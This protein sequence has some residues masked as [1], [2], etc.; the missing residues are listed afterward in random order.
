MVGVRGSEGESQSEW[1]TG[2]KVRRR[3]GGPKEVA[4]V[5]SGEVKKTVLPSPKGELRIHHT[6]GS[7]EG[8]RPSGGFV[9]YPTVRAP[10]RRRA[11]STREG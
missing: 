10:S 4:S 6:E 9:S 3:G 1:K 2:E 7:K 11:D 8:E 5:Q